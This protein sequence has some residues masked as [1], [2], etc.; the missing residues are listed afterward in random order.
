VTP[1]FEARIISASGMEPPEPCEVYALI[2]YGAGGVFRV[3]IG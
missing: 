2:Y 1:Q 3:S